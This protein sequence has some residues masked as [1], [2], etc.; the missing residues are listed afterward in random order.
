MK[1]TVIGILLLTLLLSSLSACSE[2][3][4]NPDSSTTVNSSAPAPTPSVESTTTGEETRPMHAIPESAD[5]NG[6]IFNIMYPNW[7]GYNYYFFADEANGDAMNDAIFNRTLAVEAYLNVDI[8]QYNPGYIETI[9]PTLRQSVSSS[10]DA[11]QLTLTHCIQNV[12]T[13]V[14]DGLLFNYDDLSNVDYSAAWW[15]REMMDVLRLGNNTY[16]GISDYMIPCPYAIFFSKDLIERF[17]LD[18]PYDLVY[19]GEWTL[20][21]YMNMAKAVVT[22]TDGNGKITKSDIQ[23]ICC[24]ENSKYISFMTG[25]NQFMTSRGADGRIYIDMNNEKVIDLVE[26]FV[27]LSLTDGVF[28]QDGSLSVTNGNLLFEHHTI[29]NAV[30]YRESEV[31]IG[32]LPYPKYDTTQE[33]YISLDWG[34]LMGIPATIRD[35]DMVGAVLELLAYESGNEVIPTYYDV[36]LK[37]KLARDEHT[38]AMLD[39]LFDT[40]AY[41]VGGNYFGFDGTIESLFYTIPRTAIDDQNP[42]FSSLYKTKE[43]VATKVISKFYESLDKVE[44]QDE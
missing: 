12:A 5:Y 34:G 28:A 7:Q 32:I 6:A 8:T 4:A 43:R 36:L 23:G 31:N 3:A 13:M 30:N 40:I 16:F 37:G 17:Q 35:P 25:C 9:Y 10:D 21:A 15:N 18:N 26:R 14:T 29:A 1:K 24:E 42:N 11:Y 41:E 38:V 44:S 20:D 19:S 33:N 2:S 27:A 39:I 22:D